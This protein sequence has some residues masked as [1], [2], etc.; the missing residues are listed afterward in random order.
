MLES[1]GIRVSIACLV[2][3]TLLYGSF[4]WKKLATISGFATSALEM[5]CYVRNYVINYVI[6]DAMVRVDRLTKTLV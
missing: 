2:E 3:S 6:H 5:E 4:K 1:K